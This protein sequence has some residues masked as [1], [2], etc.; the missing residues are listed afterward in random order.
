MST[1]AP[2]GAARGVGKLRL[3]VH[4][5]HPRMAQGECM[6]AQLFFRHLAVGGPLQQVEVMPAEDA[7]SEQ[8]GFKNSAVKHTEPCC[9]LHLLACFTGSILPC[10]NPAQF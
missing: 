5:S 9:F 6:L 8:A 10:W 2:S 4:T 3:C 1:S 7:P